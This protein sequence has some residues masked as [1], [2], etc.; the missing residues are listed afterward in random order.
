[1]ASVESE[2][3]LKRG[4]LVRM[5][6]STAGSTTTDDGF[7]PGTEGCDCDHCLEGTT[8]PDGTEC[9]RSHT[10]WSFKNPWLTC[11]ETDLLLHYAGG[12]TWISDVFDGPTGNANTY[13]FQLTIDV[14][15]ILSGV[16]NYTYLA[17]V[18]EDDNGGDDVCLQYGRL[19]FD[20]Q[21]DNLLTR[22]KPF[23]KVSGI[24]IADT[25]CNLCLKPEVGGENPDS[26]MSCSCNGSEW[27]IPSVVVVNIPSAPSNGACDCSEFEGD[28]YLTA[29]PDKPFGFGGV[30]DLWAVGMTAC[31]NGASVLALSCSGSKLY[32]TVHQL[33]ASSATAYT[34][35]QYQ[36]GCTDAIDF[37][38]PITMTMT[39]A[40][41]APWPDCGVDWPSEI[42]ISGPSADPHGSP[43]STGA[44][45]DD[46][47]TP[48]TVPSNPSGACCYG[49]YCLDFIDET[50]CDDFGGQWYADSADCDTSCNPTG[51]CCVSGGCFSGTSAVCDAVGG[52]FVSG[53]DCDDDPCEFGA[54]CR[55]D[56][57][58]EQSLEADCQ[59]TGGYWNGLDVACGSVNCTVRCCCYNVAGSCFREDISVAE[60]ESYLHS[61]TWS[62]VCG[63]APDCGDGAISGTPEPDGDC[64]FF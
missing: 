34:L 48:G 18:L 26:E 23:G 54:C 58:C 28:H 52:N 22:K 57:S 38:A 53:G 2:L 46:D 59:G 14:D 9:C 4:E 17:L 39:F 44:C 43:T 25:S 32:V 19:G 49:G 12:D 63:T 50:L 62:G 60:C 42:T 33:D 30:G 61:E 64:I 51:A 41:N 15:G 11:T 8:I 3:A 21:C 31:A 29:D 56:G 36:V 20:C 47:C 40:S 7:P 24:E 35:V 45:D 27:V 16:P 10:T 5:A 55:A 1:M 13:R 6:N 37:S